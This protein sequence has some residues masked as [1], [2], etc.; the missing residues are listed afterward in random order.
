MTTVLDRMTDR[1]GGALWKRNLALLEQSW[2]PVW[3]LLGNSGIVCPMVGLGDDGRPNAATFKTRQRHTDGAEV[4]LTWS[5]APSALDTPFDPT[6]PD[7]WQGIVPVIEFNGTDEQVLHTSGGTPFPYSAYPISMGAWYNVAD[8]DDATFIAISRI[9]VGNVYYNI[10]VSGFR[11]PLLVVR[12]T[13]QD[14]LTGTAVS[15]S[16]WHHVV[17][18]MAS[19]TD[20]RLYVDGVADGTDATSVTLSANIDTILIGHTGD[21][22]PSS[23]LT[24]MLAGGAIGPFV[25]NKTLTPAEVERLYNLGRAALGL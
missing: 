4:D 8:G 19:A 17:G 16:A 13:S 21:S 5:E 24:G 22:T 9:G 2:E 18:V 7:H 20:R 3:G 12:N 6:N 11:E 14:I 23:R 15:G 10:Q 25:T 1:Y